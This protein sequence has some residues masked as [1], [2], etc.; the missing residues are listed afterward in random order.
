MKVFHIITHIDL[1]GAERVAINIA[2]GGKS[3]GIEMH[4]IEVIRGTSHIS[5][6][7]IAE[8]RQAG[9]IVHR[10]PLP[11]LFHW[12]YVAEKALAWFFPL[13]FVWLWIR[14]RPDILHSHTEIPD[15]GL[16]ATLRIFPFIKPRKIVRTIHNTVLWTG[17]KNLGKRIEKFMQKRNANICISESV[18]NFYEDTYGTKPPIIYNGVEVPTSTTLSLDLLREV[19]NES[20]SICFAARLEEQ[21]GIRTLCDVLKRMSGDTRYHFYIFGEGTLSYLLDDLSQQENISIHGPIS[22]IAAYL[23]NFDYV[24]MPS[25]HEGLA[26]LSIE[27]SLSR[28]PVLANNAPGLTDTLPPDWPLMVTD[29][30]TE[31][32]LYLLRDVLP[33]VDRDALADKAYSY[34]SN[35][36]TL[37]HMQE[38]YYRF[39]G[40]VHNI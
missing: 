35:R 11:I 14:H 29:N 20:I 5:H 32:W 40:S 23:G 30:D 31:Q 37:K 6:S 18:R 21:K 1:G 12:H 22:N 36:F 34:A 24:F 2:K 38:E 19:P 4:V 16:Y 28:T 3:H 9:I 7:M 26:T 25:L 17:M 27:A 15:I 33:T 13:W 8:M 39:Y 10:A